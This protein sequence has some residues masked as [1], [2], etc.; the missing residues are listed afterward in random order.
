[1]GG[2]IRHDG[3]MTEADLRRLADER[4]LIDTLFSRLA[5][6]TAALQP[7]IPALRQVRFFCDAVRRIDRLMAVR[8]PLATLDNR[9]RALRI[10]YKLPEDSPRFLLLESAVRALAADGLR[11]VAERISSGAIVP[12]V[13]GD[14]RLRAWASVLETPD[15]EE[16][17]SYAAAAQVLR[18]AAARLPTMRRFA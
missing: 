8:I 14:E 2:G 9:L 16:E 12:P 18:E 1:M 5:S 13:G 7:E 17:P 6:D 4:R 15:L 3:E 10:D 11:T